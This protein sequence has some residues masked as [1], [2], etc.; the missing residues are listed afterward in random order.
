MSCEA[1]NLYVVDSHFLDI[2]LLAENYPYTQVFSADFPLDSAD[3]P[4]QRC[5]I[6]N[7]GR[8]P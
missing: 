3:L 2:L 7:N 5:V 4:R 8:M 1:L 6:G